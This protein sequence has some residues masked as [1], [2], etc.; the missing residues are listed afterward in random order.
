MPVWGLSGIWVAETVMKD[1]KSG[2]VADFNSGVVVD[3]VVS[4]TSA[5]ESG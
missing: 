2:L 4:S 3:A 1:C 5:V